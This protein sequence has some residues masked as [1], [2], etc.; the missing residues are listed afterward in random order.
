MTTTTSYV[1]YYSTIPGGL[2][3]PPDP[4]AGA[5]APSEK[6]GK[7]IGY[8]WWW[9]STMESPAPW[10]CTAVGDPSPTRRRFGL[11]AN[12]RSQLRLRCGDPGRLVRKSP[13]VQSRTGSS[14]RA[15]LPAIS[16]SGP[17]A[18]P[19]K[20]FLNVCGSAAYPRR[21]Q[22][23]FKKSRHPAAPGLRN[24]GWSGPRPR[25][26]DSSVSYSCPGL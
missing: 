16:C 25:I 15:C 1:Q 23:G 6:G 10:E 26:S 17:S 19:G 12:Y 5:R 4:P 7:D 8:S 20:I 22:I 24:P 11:M 3:A 9:W 14:F 18:G 2:S 13:D 21:S